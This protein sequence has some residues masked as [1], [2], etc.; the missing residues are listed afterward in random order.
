VGGPRSTLIH[1]LIVANVCVCVHVCVCMCACVC[2]F[3]S[4]K[5]KT[6]LWTGSFLLRE[7]VPDLFPNLGW[8]WQSLA[9]IGLQIFFIFTWYSPYVYV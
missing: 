1:C 4:W 8:Y 7:P 5:F 6:E 9:F 2:V 3:K